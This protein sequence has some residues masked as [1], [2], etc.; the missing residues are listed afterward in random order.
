VASSGDNG[1]GY[2]FAPSV[3]FPA[4]AP[5]VISVGGTTLTTTATTTNGV[6]TYSY[7]S[8]SAWSG[9]TGGKSLFEALPSY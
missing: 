9:S 1:G 4:V 8:E 3:S 5:N 6:T 2:W 7:G